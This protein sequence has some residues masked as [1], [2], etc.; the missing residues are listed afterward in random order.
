MAETTNTQT[1]G[2]R[3]WPI[4]EGE[5]AATDFT[6]SLDGS[7]IFV[8]G[9]PV[10]HEID[11]PEGSIWTH[12]MGCKHETTS[13]CQFDLLR[14]VR[15]TVRPVIAF[16]TA[17]VI[18]EPKNGV[19]VADGEVSFDLTEPTQM[20]VILDGKLTPVLHVFADPPSGPAPAAD[21]PKVHYFGPGVHE[22]SNLVLQD[23]ETLYL[24]GGALLRGVIGPDEVG[25]KSERTGLVS[26]GGLIR[27]MKATNV[28]VCGRGMIDSSLIPHAGKS[29]VS[30]NGCKGV[31]IEGIVIRNSANWSVT[32][33]NSDEV[34][35]SWVKQVCGRLNSDGI[36]P[37]SS[38]RVH[39][40][41]CFIRNR[42]DSIAVKAMNPLRP[43][44]AILVERCRIWNDWGYAL[45]ITY[46]TRSD[47]HGVIFRDCEVLHAQ[48]WGLGIHV[49]DSGTMSD[50]TFERIRLRNLQG[51]WIKLNV[52]SDM[53][54]TDPERGNIRDITFTS[55]THVEDPA[56][57]IELNGV[58]ATHGV[59]RV[60][61][62]DMRIGARRITT[63]ADLP[64]RK[65]AF[66]EDLTLRE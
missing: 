34:E 4:P 48:H 54:G 17:V 9:A 47:I 36:N 45:G 6:V 14:T 61:F 63:L 40:H 10:L 32:I 27:A 51:K 52:G 28:T 18:P 25:K 59:S 55:I 7:P 23:G 49:T 21:D 5:V 50:I 24:A 39:I 26:Y 2:F 12:K 44:F 31:K 1:A 37:V 16:K 29:C 38:R 19:T 15:V 66:V 56:K 58:D 42:D 3:T 22:I 53:W 43:S 62:S 30:F 35:A 57:E 11:K 65:N 20:T 41:D 60:V 13:F 46:E 64:I 33:L 8:F